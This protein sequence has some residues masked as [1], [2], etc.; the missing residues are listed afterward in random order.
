MG[1]SAGAALLYARVYAF[2]LTFFDD[3][4]YVGE[5]ARVQAGLSLQNLEWALTT[6]HFSNWHPLTWVSYMLDVQLFG[7]DVGAMHLVNA[8]LH[9]ANSGI[10][11]LA[12]DR[13]T[14]ARGR[15]AFVALLFA[16]H[17]QHVESVAWVAERK[18][19]LSTFFGLLALLAYARYAE[20]RGVVRYALV[21]LAFALSLMAK[22]MWVTFP[23][24]ALLLDA[25]PLQRIE[26]IS[27]AQGRDPPMLEQVSVRTVLLEKAPWLALSAASSFL[28][29]LAQHG[30]GA[31]SGPGLGGQLANAVVSYVLY[32]GKTI[33]P[34]SLAV[35]YPFPV[36]GYSGIEVAA[37][38]A[39]LAVALVVV[40]R[41][42]RRWPWLAVGFAWY[43]GTLVPVIGIVQVGGQA[44]ADRYTYLPSIGLSVALAWGAW[45]WAGTW[46]SGMPI[47]IGAIAFSIMLILLT[48][49]QIGHWSDHV[50][51]FRHAIEVTG[52][53]AR[54]H[55][56]LSDGLRKAGRLDE[57]LAEA[58]EAVRI[59]PGSGR[60]HMNLAIVQVDLGRL[61]EAHLTLRKAINL[62]PKLAF[63]WAL[64][65]EVETAI[66]SPAEGERMIA[67]AAQMA[68]EDADIAERLARV[69]AYRAGSGR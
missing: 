53:N 20:R 43:V 14:G 47:R 15:S 30:G 46:R 44:M 16:I 68:P 66:G 13:M 28:T 56:F 48:W 61:D 26:G 63:A 23:F 24:L 60:L 41:N 7:V 33:W 37:A 25:W 57:A 17:P 52:P 21:T 1:L 67:E 50:T 5:N 49:R 12:L 19:V 11:F 4:R 29:V 42:A 32:V 36:G 9:A 18:D 65:G 35:Y 38:A 64:L 6:L 31:V 51:L 34:V 62:D 39:V 27:L 10:L 54:A 58:R 45:A 59:E 55:A 2:P 3:P 69:R 40:V 8:L 22:P